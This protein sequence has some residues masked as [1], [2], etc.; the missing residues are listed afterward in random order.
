M[1]E[2]LAVAEVLAVAV[3]EVVWSYRT[4]EGEF[5]HPTTPAD[6]GFER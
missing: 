3:A 4:S 1:C 2:R 6:R 5:L